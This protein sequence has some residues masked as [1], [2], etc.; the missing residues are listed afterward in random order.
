MTLLCTE[1]ANR[2]QI[3][4]DG[5]MTIFQAAQLKPELLEAVRKTARNEIEVD[6]SGV[7][8]IDT[9]GVQLM[10]MLKREAQ[11]LE[12]SLTFTHHSPP[13]LGVIELLHLGS[14]LGDPL[15]LTA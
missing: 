14:T 15:L 4:L 8:E 12:R 7:E 11:R 9:A 2:A 6:L 10:L 3:K 5:E 13:V 1:V